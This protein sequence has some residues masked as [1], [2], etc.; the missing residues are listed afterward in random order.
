MALTMGNYRGYEKKPYCSAHYP[1]PKRFTV[2]TDTPELLRVAQNTRVVSN[3]ASSGR[4]NQTAVPNQRNSLPSS[5]GHIPAYY[6]AT[7]TDGHNSSSSHVNL[8][9]SYDS[10]FLRDQSTGTRH[11]CT[12]LNPRHSSGHSVCCADVRYLPSGRSPT[13]SSLTPSESMASFKSQIGSYRT[14]QD[15]CYSS[16]PGVVT[17]VV[18]PTTRAYPVMKY[19]AMYDYEA[20]EDDEVTF[21]EGD[22][23]LDGDP[24]TTGW[25]YG[26]VQ[27][28][29]QFGMLPSNYVEPI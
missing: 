19:R 2:V 4:C 28:T 9:P 22:I 18:N 8:G 3:V 11:S 23:I 7:F 1:Q 29:G 26:T 17:S 14:G 12:F 15:Y 10:S 13:G 6:S 21:I 27:R 25:M 24:I 20:I 16:E 5:D